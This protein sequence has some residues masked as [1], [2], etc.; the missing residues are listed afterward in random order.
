LEIHDDSHLLNDDLVIMWI[1]NECSQFPL[2]CNILLVRD[3]IIRYQPYPS[4]ISFPTST[5]YSFRDTAFL[6]PSHMLASDV[7]AISPRG[8]REYLSVIWMDKSHSWS[9]SLNKYFQSTQINLN[10]FLLRCDV[11]YHQSTLPVLVINMISWSK[12]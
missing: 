4:S 2:S 1:V 5:L 8:P 11:W 10:N 6:W 3:L 7:N 12:D 9:M